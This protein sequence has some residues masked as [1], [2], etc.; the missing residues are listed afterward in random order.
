MAR[1]EDDSVEGMDRSMALVE[2]SMKVTI[3]VLIVTGQYFQDRT[4]QVVEMPRQMEF[5]V[6]SGYNAMF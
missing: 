2:I 4:Q 1:T 6:G 3:E 5:I